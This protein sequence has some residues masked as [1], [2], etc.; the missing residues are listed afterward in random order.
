MPCLGTIFRL[1]GD[2]FHRWIVISEPKNGK[3]LCVSVI[4]ESKCP[5]S[6][7]KIK[8]GDHACITKPSSISYFHAREFGADAIDRELAAGTNVESWANCS[9]QLVARI[10][11]GAKKADDLTAKFLDYL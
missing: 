6:P 9:Q 11:T 7:C 1:K 5:D 10:I 8:I 2:R 3:V 4:D